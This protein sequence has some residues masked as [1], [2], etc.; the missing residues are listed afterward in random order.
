MLAGWTLGGCDNHIC[1][2]GRAIGWSQ[3]HQRTGLWAA[4]PTPYEDR[5]KVLSQE[6][7]KQACV[8]HR[9]LT[10]PWAFWRCWR[11]VRGFLSPRSMDCKQA[12]T[13]ER[14]QL[15][16]VVVTLIILLG[17]IIMNCNKSV[18]WL[19]SYE[20]IHLNLNG[21]MRLTQSEPQNVKPGRQNKQLHLH[22]DGNKQL[23]TLI[24]QSGRLCVVVLCIFY[25][26]LGMRWSRSHQ[27]TMFAFNQPVTHAPLCSGRLKK[28]KKK[29]TAPGPFFGVF[30]LH[31]V[32]FLTLPDGTKV[33]WTHSLADIFPAYSHSDCK[34]VWEKETL[35]LRDL[36]TSM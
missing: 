16:L 3:C 13:K 30:F 34:G 2:E 23:V 22:P 17:N 33:S 9:T 1:P 10:W 32:L 12:S 8:D 5:E 20:T 24:T 28:T 21:V 14:V 29:K 11:T 31:A 6:H 19:L 27:T 36:S 25:V 18:C 7:P 15:S 4:G 35:T 26:T